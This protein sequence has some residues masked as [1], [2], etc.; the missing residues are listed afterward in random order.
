[1]FSWAVLASS[2]TSLLVVKTM[3]ERPPVIVSFLMVSLGGGTAILW[4]IFNL[5]THV[6][7]S[8]PGIMISFIPYILWK[9]YEMRTKLFQEESFKRSKGKI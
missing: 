7:E 5:H 9:L 3:S 6:Y 4:R 2:L 1:M 8:F